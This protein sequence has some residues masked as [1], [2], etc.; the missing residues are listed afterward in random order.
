M[1]EELKNELIAVL[2]KMT[3]AK[4]PCV[5]L[6]FSNDKFTNLRNSSDQQTAQLIINQIESSD[7]MKEEFVKEL[8]AITIRELEDLQEKES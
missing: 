8:E 5:F 4:I 6:A 3:D 1:N 2:Q 7:G